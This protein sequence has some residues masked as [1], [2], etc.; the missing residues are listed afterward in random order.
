MRDLLF[1]V[2]NLLNIKFEVALKGSRGNR[3]EKVKEKETEIEDRE[4]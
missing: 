1:L 2:E 3:K 4:N